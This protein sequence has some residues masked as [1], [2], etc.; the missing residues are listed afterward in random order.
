M[1][2]KT[3]NVGMMYGLMGGA[4]SIL[5]SLMLYLG[6][7]KW[8]VSPIAYFGLVIPIAFAVL[9]ALRQ[10]KMGG[11]YLEFSQA[12]KTLFLCFVIMAI[13]GTL[14]SYVLLNII[15]IPFREALAQETA[16]KT[17]Q[18]MQKLGATQQQI[19]KATTDALNGNN[20]TVGKMA[21]GTAFYLIF[22]FLISLL[23]AAIV[24]K[25][26]PPF[27]NTLNA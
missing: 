19:D 17:A 9:A 20:Y 25:K 16:E 2:Q 27:E 6:G 23:I 3:E 18:F 21:L 4:A 15:D 5:F 1:E 22:W 13:L 12:L 11:G 8:F 7:V 24:K 10:K 26:K 14:F